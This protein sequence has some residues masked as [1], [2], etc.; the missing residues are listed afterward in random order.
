[1]AM[2]LMKCVGRQTS[3]VNWASAL[4]MLDGERSFLL[5]SPCCMLLTSERVLLELLLLL[6]LLILPALLLLEL[7]SSFPLSIVDDEWS[8]PNCSSACFRF[9]VPSVSKADPDGRRA[10]M[11]FKLSF[12]TGIRP[13]SADARRDARRRCLIGFLVSDGGGV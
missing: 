11:S 4:M 3:A 7:P 5:F 6:L 13:S 8:V 10:I 12:F 1:M 2:R 9:P